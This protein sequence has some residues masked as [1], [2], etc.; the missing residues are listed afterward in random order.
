MGVCDGEILALE[1]PK[2]YPVPQYPQ[3]RSMVRR[4]KYK[5]PFLED[6]AA[7]E[8]KENEAGLT[9]LEEQMARDQLIIDHESFRRERWEPLKQFRSKYDNEYALSLSILSASDLAKK[10]R[11]L[12]KVTL[13]AI[14]L[15]I[16]SQDNDR[17]FSYLELLNFAD[18]LK[19]CIKL[20]DMMNASELSQKIA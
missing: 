11:E 14:R 18:S 7:P 6:E 13:N 1:T 15:C 2:S 17:V 16:L 4:F 3:Q 19:M 9:Q 10:K 12:D 8:K 20:C 5:I